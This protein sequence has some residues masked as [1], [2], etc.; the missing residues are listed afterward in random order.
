M[1]N[2]CGLTNSRTWDNRLLMVPPKISMSLARTLAVHPN[3][4]ARINRGVTVASL[5]LA[6]KMAAIARNDDRIDCDLSD[7]RPDLLEEPIWSE[8]MRM[9]SRH[10]KKRVKSP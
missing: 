10:K 6:C 9:V 3:T 5:K 8:I 7:W 1:I 4:I 2:F